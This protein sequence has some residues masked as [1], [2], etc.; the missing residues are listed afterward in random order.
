LSDE[1]FEEKLAEAGFDVEEG[2]GRKI[3]T[4]KD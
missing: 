3:F 1:D 4:E 2:D